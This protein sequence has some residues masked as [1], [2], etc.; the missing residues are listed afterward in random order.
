MKGSSPPSGRAE[1]AP[2]AHSEGSAPLRQESTT[3][4]RT[5]EASFAAPE[6]DSLPRLETPRFKGNS[7][8]AVPPSLNQVGPYRLLTEL[9]SGG[10]ATVYLG[11]RQ[12]VFGFEK[13]VAVKCIHE[14]LIHNPQF[15]EMFVD[16]ARIAASVNHP[17]VC[18]VFD[19]GRA[20]SGY[21]MA[22]EFLQGEP[23]SRVLTK[24]IS[25]HKFLDEPRYARLI[26]R[27]IA[28]LAEGLHAV[29]S[30][31]DQGGNELGVVH[32]DVSPQNLFVLFD[33]TVRVT[34]LGI[35]YARKRVH[36]TPRQA[37]KGKVSYL[38]PEVIER[39][40]FDRR[41]DVWSLGVV[42]WELLTGR[43]LFRSASEGETLLAVM[44]RMVQPPS[45]FNAGVPKQ[46]D[47]I[48]LKA[49]ERDQT[50]RYATARDFSRALEQF[51][52]STRDTVPAMDVAQ[53]LNQAFPQS[54]GECQKLVE[55]AREAAFDPTLH[56][57][58]SPETEGTATRV[59]VPYKVSLRNGIVRPV[60][61]VPPVPAAIAQATPT[62]RHRFLTSPFV[63][64]TLCALVAV[65][66]LAVLRSL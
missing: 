33:G 11:V 1:D 64:A 50:Q 51:L 53:W 22:M 32:R 19:F 4:L 15:W 44:S 24:A 38:A 6:A 25:D 21:Y 18:S 26:A 36:H 65:L 27:V 37:I 43:R 2:A 59:D 47:E 62:E 28:N 66:T 58:I 20:D 13:F 42:L 5:A 46:L 55:Q 60:Q 30:I 45:S 8:A 52:S 14:H 48:V 35:A 57:L 17:Y 63:I 9:A 16:E 39:S 40:S 56:S 49:L 34:D 12:G 7:L 54:V 23:L 3:R 61:T 31:R 41:A 29:H 10:M